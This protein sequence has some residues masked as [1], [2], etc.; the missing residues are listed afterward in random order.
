MTNGLFP[1]TLTAAGI[2]GL[3]LLVL[4]FRCIMARLRLMKGSTNNEDNKAALQTAMRVMANFCE[5][6][7][8]ILII[9]ALLEASKVA[10]IL[11][12]GLAGLLVVGRLSHAWGMSRNDGPGASRFIGTLT[13]WLALLVGSVS[14]LY[15]ALLA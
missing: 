14:C 7:P 8:I 9:I 12:Y 3:L 6:V 11:P 5:Y 15:I 4:A 1:A 2:L 10:P 13:T